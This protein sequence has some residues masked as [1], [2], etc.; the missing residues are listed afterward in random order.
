MRHGSP[1]LLLVPGLLCDRASWAGQVAALGAA[2][3]CEVFDHGQRASIED[4]AAHVLASAGS[5]RFALAGHSM[6][7]R[8]ALEVVRQAPQR[9][10][11]LALL[12][13]GYQARAGGEAGEQERRS[14]YALLEV[15]RTQGMRAMGERWARGMVHPRRIDTPLFEEILAMIERSTPQRFEA[16]VRALLERPDATPVLTAIRCPTLLV[17][18]REDAWSPLARHEEMQR[19]IAGSVLAVIED[20]GHMSPMEQPQAVGAALA[21]WLAR[22]GD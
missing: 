21:A 8:V 12:D 1:L 15:A 5:E 10:R 19:A 4:M 2:A 22:L 7:G 9:V 3:R 17:C 18:G 13:T 20:S 11:G 14:R 16:Q 6:G